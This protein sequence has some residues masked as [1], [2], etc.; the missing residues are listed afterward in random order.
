[1]ENINSMTKKQLEKYPIDLGQNIPN[2]RKISKAELIKSVNEMSDT[3]GFKVKKELNKIEEPNT[4]F[5]LHKDEANGL[6]LNKEKLNK[7]MLKQIEKFYGLTNDRIRQLCNNINKG[8]PR[9]KVEFKENKDRIEFKFY[10]DDN[11][12][13]VNGMNINCDGIGES[14]ATFLMNF[15]IKLYTEIIKIKIFQKIQRIKN[16]MHV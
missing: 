11:K 5:S 12:G 2:K 14:I 7:K 8:S 3:W 13:G 1:M 15:I 4:Y 10:F 9:Y 16:T 6:N